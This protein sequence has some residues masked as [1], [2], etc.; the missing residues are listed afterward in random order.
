MRYEKSNMKS[1]ADWAET[2]KRGVESDELDYKAAMNWNTL[3]R[4]GRAK[5]VRHCLAMANTKGGYIVVGVGEDS[6]GRPCVFSGLSKEEIHSFDP[7]N[8]GPF[9]NNYVDPPIDFTIERPTVDGKHYAIFVIRPFTALPHV[10]T[11]GVDNELQQGVFYIRT[12][13]ASSRPAVRAT[14]LHQLIQ[15]ALR[16]QREM[17]GRML[18]GIL[19]ETKEQSEKSSSHFEDEAF[20]ARN[21]FKRRLPAPLVADNVR[22]EICV[23]PDEYSPDRFSFEELL[24]ATR[25]AHQLRNEKEWLSADDVEKSYCTNTALR[26]FPENSGKFYQIGKDGLLLCTRLVSAVNHRL[27]CKFLS[28]WVIEAIDFISHLYTELGFLEQMLE[29]RVALANTG[30]V[31]LDV[32]DG[33]GD[34]K[35]KASV[36]APRHLPSC[37]SNEINVTLRRTAADLISGGE[38]HAIRIIR[39]I[40]ESFNVDKHLHRQ[41]RQ[42]MQSLWGRR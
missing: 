29:I 28:I 1:A 13:D 18:R 25:S 24:Y 19:Y 2:I 30:G 27:S 32:T 8:V 9:I 7:S 14:E 31:I 40:G 4:Q 34:S 22:I 11:G 42:Q 26:I 23:F 35:H 17:L 37:G 41:L 33:D 38:A 36:N 6:S 20:T 10:C 5:L 39:E 15:R 21:Y 12:V 16:N 3:T